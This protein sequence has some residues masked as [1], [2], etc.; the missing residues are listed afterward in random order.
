[1]PVPNSPLHTT[2]AFSSSPVKSF[3][4]LS[5]KL[6]IRSAGNSFMMVSSA[7]L[8]PVPAIPF[9]KSASCQSSNSLT[10]KK[11]RP[12]KPKIMESKLELFFGTGCATMPAGSAGGSTSF[13]VVKSCAKLGVN[14]LQL[15][16]NW[17]SGITHGSQGKRRPISTHIWVCIA[18]PSRTR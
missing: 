17:P 9:K 15:A 16:L 1:M 4:Q 14:D 2:S 3:W 12:T 7:T 10:T 18:S 11:R 5:L 8:L 6:Q 13:W